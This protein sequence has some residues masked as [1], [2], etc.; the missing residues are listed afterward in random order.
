MAPNQLQAKYFPNQGLTDAGYIFRINKKE[1]TGIAARCL[2]EGRKCAVGACFPNY[3]F[4]PIFHPTLNQISL[5]HHSRL[6][7]GRGG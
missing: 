5:W 4:Y 7:I 6:P 3:L 1:D 2:P